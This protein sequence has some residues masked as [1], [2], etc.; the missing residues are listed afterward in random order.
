MREQPEDAS[1]RIDEIVKELEATDS[2]EQ[3]QM[4]S[5]MLQRQLAISEK[6]KVLK[7]KH[8]ARNSVNCNRYDRLKS[9]LS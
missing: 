8:I 4:V 5:D 7:V 6:I 9:R 3:R 2:P 1:E